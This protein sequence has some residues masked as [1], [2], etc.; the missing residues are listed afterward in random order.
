MSSF[1]FVGLFIYSAIAAS[2]LA[3]S[4]VPVVY[5]AADVTT[6][7]AGRSVRIA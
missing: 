5:V 1:S 4:G 7:E 2:E 3:V 6:V